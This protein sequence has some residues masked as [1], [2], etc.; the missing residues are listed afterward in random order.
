MA[1]TPGHTRQRRMRAVVAGRLF[2]ARW[3]L[4]AL[5]A[6]LLIAWAFGWLSAALA[7]IVFAV[8]FATAA[9]A[10]RRS[11]RPIE[12]DRQGEDGH[13]L[14]TISVA[15]L[16]SAVP[17]A[18]LIFDGDGAALHA[19]EAAVAAFG[20]FAPG[21]PL[22]RRFRAPEMQQLIDEMLSGTTESSVVDYVER[23]PIERVF[24]VTG[25]RI[26]A[27]GALFVLVFKDQSETRRIDR[28][29]ADFIAN[30]SHE[31][32]TPLASI[33]GFVEALR[34]PARND[35]AARE[36]F[37]KIMQEQTGRMARLIDD[38][39]S[40]SRLEMKPFLPAGVE[41][42]IRE[43]IDSVI[44]SLG[45]LAREAGVEVIREFP[46]GP[47]IVA[48]NRDELFQVFENLLENA[49]KYGQSGGKVVVS[50]A[51]PAAPADGETTVTFRDFGPGIAAEHIPRITERFYRVDVDTSRG[52]KGTGLGL[53]IVKHILTRHNARL[54]IRSEV[55]KGSAFAVHFP[56]RAK[57]P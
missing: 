31:L 38:L 41:V 44:D 46:A 26:R 48:G 12:P 49:C 33:T 51:P 9:L 20:P 39:L 45:P 6:C 8:V 21:F 3:P 43:A 57:K 40:L 14:E 53:A 23:V 30:A 1:E 4:A 7:A 56:A 54:S 24:R 37:L 50:I 25:T 29:R 34:G 42:D 17:D 55:G 36:S 13:R 28:M 32:R 16:A 52:R 35:V 11:I 19:N 15:D 5:A 27:D 22:Q 18:I 10:P 2:G 47:V